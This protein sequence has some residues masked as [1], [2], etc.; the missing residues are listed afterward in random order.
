LDA[1]ADSLQIYKKDRESC[2]DLFDYGIRICLSKEEAITAKK[3]RDAIAKKVVSDSTKKFYR[4]KN[5]FYIQTPE[6][7]VRFDLSSVKMA[8]GFSMRDSG[9]LKKKE[10]YEVEIE[11]IANRTAST[12]NDIIGNFFTYINILLRLYQNSSTIIGKSEEDTV[13]EA[14]IKLVGTDAF[15]AANPTTLDRKN[16]IADYQPN[17]LT[18]KD[19]AITLKADG[20]RNLLFVDANG[21]MYLIDGHMNARN[22]GLQDEGW[23]GSI[24]E[25]EL[26]DGAIF[27]AYDMLFAND[28]DIRDLPLINSGGKDR[29][30]SLLK[31]VKNHKTGGAITIEEKVYKM[32]GENIFEAA[33]ELW[34]TKAKYAVDGLI[35]VPVAQSYPKQIGTWKTLFKWKPESMNSIDFLVRTEKDPRGV[36]VKMPYL[37]GDNMMMQYK[38]LNLFV[39]KKTGDEYG[40]TEFAPSGSAIAK[41]NVLLNDSE[42]MFAIDPRTGVQGEIMDGGIAEFVY[43]M[44]GGL[45][46]WRPIRV[47]ADKKYPNNERVAIDIWNN[48]NNPITE[49]MITTGILPSE[50]SVTA[51]KPYY[52][53]A[54]YMPETRLPMQNF[55]NLVIKAELIL[56][57]A[58]LAPGKELLDFACGKGGD[59]SKW[60]SAGFQRVISIDINKPC[61][62]Y[63]RNYYDK[64]RP[65][66]S[67][68][69]KPDVLFVWGDSSKAMFP[70]Y[71]I[72][73]S[74]DAVRTLKEV[75]P[76]KYMF[77][78]VSCQF[79][80]H[81]F[82]ESESKLRQLLQ[83]V[84]DNLKI[85]GYFIGTCFDGKRVEELFKGKQTL[86]EGGEIWSIEK[87]YKTAKKGKF[88]KEIEVM[89]KSIGEKHKEYLVDFEM[90]T[91][92]AAE[93]KLEVVK[94]EEFGKKYETMRNGNIRNISQMSDTEKDFSFLNNYFIFKKTAHSADALLKK[95]KIK[96]IKAVASESGK[97][98][99]GEGEKESKE[100][101]K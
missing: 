80:I 36:D 79:C 38:V 72:G 59:L 100:E 61:I 94:V 97:E 24:I 67:K 32:G 73:L 69:K 70:N 35:F 78:V 93:Y 85:D 84:N 37:K 5:R 21:R 101:E 7:I 29:L 90:L 15:I 75:V 66:N 82:F 64:F 14:Y 98:G 10:N 26:V 86:V 96:K 56:E 12:D 8:D 9:V 22:T 27:L 2:V 68:N 62:D 91:N 45:F 1:I 83:N 54:E 55:H 87:L 31:F 19:Y 3:E 63:A 77:D 16:L 65:K 11:V 95:I 43:D 88:G 74:K 33:K 41:A 25:G 60:T 17:I 28:K 13:K 39:A 76:A 52:A 4:M 89:V 71:D 30:T 58:A 99:E 53:C 34:Q 48:I 92:M 23:Y 6:G 50:S 20:D 51:D 46:K 81:Y 44:R 18:A 42:R 47:R 40:L 49:E 57:V